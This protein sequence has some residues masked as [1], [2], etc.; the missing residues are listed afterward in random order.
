MTFFACL[1]VQDDSSSPNGLTGFAA[2]CNSAVS[3]ILSSFWSD[4]S[5]ASA[6]DAV[7]SGSAT[8]TC[9]ASRYLSSSNGWRVDHLT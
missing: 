1:L 3:D 9:L 7:F 8:S 2:A 5:T 4:G 6:A